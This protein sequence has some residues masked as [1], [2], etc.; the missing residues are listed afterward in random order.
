MTD[1]SWINIIEVLSGKKT[2]K[3][4][5]MRGWIYR[6][7][8][9]G[10]IVFMILRD[11][12][13]VLQTTIKKGNLKDNEFEDAKKAL[14]ESSLELSGVV[15]KDERAP[16]GY[17]LQANNVNII[18]FAEP[19]PI[20]KDQSPEFL[21]D[22]RHLW[23]RSQKLTSVFKIRST[24]VGA[25]HKFFREK[26]YY[27]FDAPVLQPN[28]CE[29]GSTLFEVKYYNNKTYLSQSWQLYAEAA[30]FGLEK[31]YNM[32][33]TF[34]AEKSKTSRHLSEFWMAEMEAAWVD[35]HD[36][37]EIAKNEIKYILKEVLKNNKH[38][39]DSLGQDISR[40]EEISK[41]IFP[42][43]TYTK[44]LEILKEKEN[45][46]IG[47]GKDLRTTEED[48]LMKH[49]KTPVVVTN[50]PLEI[51]AFYK[52]VDPKDQKTA[53]C[54]DM[55]APGGYGEI[56]G[57]S[58]RSQNIN[59]MKKRLKEMGEKIENYQ[60]YFDLRRY[61]SV[62]HSGYGLGVER[63]IAWI[64]GLDNIKDAIPFPRTVLRFRP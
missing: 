49:F 56:V 38:E 12:T 50:Y 41:A 30:V 3:N 54:F 37:S 36:V 20:V 60:W 18:N 59:E 21:L 15:K 35:L 34:R 40:L 57:G 9:S 53:L 14:I 22:Q 32:G 24:V 43:I 61:G 11:A 62:P 7:R 55:L 44:A 6:T 26:G 52:P 10:N 28:Q 25:I 48:A 5:K 2:G 31:I 27:E 39:L 17:E 47:W 63:V 29:G 1:T 45:L 64:C 16:G 33:P 19:F 58:Q 13:G 51:M 42:T 23:I 4:V 46:D 8:S